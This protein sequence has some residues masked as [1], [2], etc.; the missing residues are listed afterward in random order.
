MEMELRLAG[1]S[2]SRDGLRTE[3]ELCGA[4]QKVGEERDMSV[5]NRLAASSGRSLEMVVGVR[6]NAISQLL[7]SHML[8]HPHDVRGV[9]F[10]CS[11]PRTI[12][13]FGIACKAPAS[14]EEN[15][16]LNGAPLLPHDAGALNGI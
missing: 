10:R 4:L 15:C 7:S 5:T 11:L 8:P 12:C 2:L 3:D 16:G 9:R 1:S 13:S 14:L 6:G